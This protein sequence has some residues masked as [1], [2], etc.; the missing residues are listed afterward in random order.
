MRKDVILGM[1][2]G[3]GMLAV[4]IGY[5]TLSSNNKH[6]KRGVDV[7]IADVEPGGAGDTAGQTGDAGTTPD[8]KSGA[9]NP[10]RLSGPPALTEKAD[11]V[12]GPRL[13]AGTKVSVTPGV[14]DSQP[15]VGPTTPDSPGT[16]EDPTLPN[17]D[18]GITRTPPSGNNDMKGPASPVTG[19]AVHPAD[20]VTTKMRTHKVQQGETF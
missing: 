1:T 11:P 2:I 17:G 13:W 6:D 12:W 8:G 9:G 18:G 15:P 19:G 7:G 14:N 4:V 10:T 20:P 3:G 5:L 16:V